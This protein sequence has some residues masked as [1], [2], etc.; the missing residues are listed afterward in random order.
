M[1]YK[2]NYYIFKIIRKSQNLVYEKVIY[3]ILNLLSNLDLI[4]MQRDFKIFT[5]LKNL[6]TI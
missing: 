5:P 6:H 2:K 1:T 3:L 4:I